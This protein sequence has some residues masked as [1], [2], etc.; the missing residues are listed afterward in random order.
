VAEMASSNMAGRIALYNLALSYEKSGDVQ[1]GIQTCLTFLDR[2]GDDGKG[3]S[4]V[5]RYRVMANL[6]ALSQRLNDAQFTGEIR[7]QTEAMLNG[8][9]DPYL[10]IN[11]A[12]HF[13]RAGHQ[14]I[15]KVLLDRA[16]EDAIYKLDELKKTEDPYP[17]LK[18]ILRRLNEL[19]Q[20]DRVTSLASRYESI[21]L[22]DKE[23]NQPEPLYDA[24]YER[25]LALIRQ[26]TNDSS[27]LLKLAKGCLI[28]TQQLGYRQAEA[29]F[30]Y[31]MSRMSD[32]KEKWEYRKQLVERH[33]N[34]IRSLEAKVMIAGKYYREGNIEIAKEL[35]QEAITQAAAPVQYQHKNNALYLMSL[36]WTKEGLADQAIQTHNDLEQYPQNSFYIKDVV[37]ER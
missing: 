14:D 37:D 7:E 20:Y 9:R 16:C 27:Q 26:G 17:Y 6:L 3:G 21:A 30:L 23:V 15:E 31:Q 12:N 13:G 35:A 28:K 36:I 19:N 10:S 29:K 24:Q 5:W 18:K 11:I 34:D 32:E 25:I 4:A 2:Y 22:S 8:V 1:S 33:S